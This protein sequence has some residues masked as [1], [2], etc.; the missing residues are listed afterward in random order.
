MLVK[1]WKKGNPC[2]RLVG[3]KTGAATMENSMEFLQK[4]KSEPA[5]WSSDSTSGYLFK[6]TQN[7]DL[8]EYMHPYIYFIIIYSS[9]TMEATQVPTM[10]EQIKKPAHLHHAILFSH[11]R[12]WNPAIYSIMDGL[13]RSY[14][15]SDKSGKERQIPYDFT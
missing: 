8:K 9:Q 7:T 15:Q 5:L 3:M 12:E 2:V 14:A 11:K 4:I 1:M 10:N 6:E 13:T